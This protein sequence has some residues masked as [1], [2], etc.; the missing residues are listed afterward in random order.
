M[1][2]LGLLLVCLV[3]ICRVD[4]KKKCETP[5]EEWENRWTR[6]FDGVVHFEGEKHF[7]N[8][9]QLTFSGANAEGYFSFDDTKLTYQASNGD[10]GTSCDQIY[11]LD[12]T[13][14]PDQTTPRRLSTGLGACTCSF[15][16]DDNKHRIYAGTF[17]Q[18]Q[19][20][21]SDPTLSS[22]PMKQCDERNPKLLT[23]PKLKELCSRNG[24]YIWDVYPE[25]D[26]FLVNEYGNVVKR[27]T[28]SPGYDAEGVVSPDGKT[29][30]FTSKRNGDLDL[31][32]M[33]TD[34]SNVRQLTS[35]L[36]Y[37]GGGFFSP[38]GTKIIYRASRPTTPEE[39]QTYKDYL[40]YNMVEPL[41]MELFVYDLASNTSRQLTSLGGANWAPYYL[42][43]NKR[44]IF[45]SD[46]DVTAG[47]GAFS[48]W[49]INDDGTGL[50]KVTGGDQVFDSFPMMSYSGKWLVW[51]SS[52]NATGKYDVNL[53]IADW[54]DGSE[55][56]A[57]NLLT[58]ILLLLSVMFIR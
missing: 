34:G 35:E 27:L 47:F 28:D 29:I 4:A 55:R 13:L 44:V 19:I 26:I 50:E 9:V 2:R 10:Y 38:D 42:N 31:Y 17:M 53:F 6:R 56:K 45:S 52:R 25:M 7:K 11:E 46:H 43:D 37:N 1:F 57:A 30:L 5:E 23:D 49:L 12:L 33:D 58:L 3:G 24:S 15:F 41:A 20:N 22:C 36:G 39:I 21:T 48:L 16:L 51:G 54:V 14:P 40:E 18:A 8:V 32:L